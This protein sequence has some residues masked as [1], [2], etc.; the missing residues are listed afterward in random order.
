MESY[1]KTMITVQ[2]S[3]KASVD[4]V[5]K[6]WTSPEDILVWNTA[7]DDWHT[8]KA[9]NN[10]E[11]GGKFNYRMEAKDGSFGFDF[12]G[13]YDQVNAQQ[14]IEITLGDERK[15]KVIFTSENSITEVI[16]TFEAE[17][18]NSVE[19]QQSGWQAILDNFKKYVENIN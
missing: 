7:S 14:V 6:C 8:T 2:A 1:E 18:K 10:L 16:E 4:L 5:W 11:A 17:S 15:M 3:I 19:L 12:W 9:E 13:I